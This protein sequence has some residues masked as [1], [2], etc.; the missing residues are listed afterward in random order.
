MGA[1]AAGYTVHAPGTCECTAC[2]GRV[3]HHV[4]WPPAASLGPR[5]Y[6]CAC[7]GSYAPPPTPPLLEGAMAAVRW[8]EPE[9]TEGYTLHAC[10]AG[11]AG[12][13]CVTAGAGGVERRWLAIAGPGGFTVRPAEVMVTH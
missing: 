4:V 8:S 3:W 9:A 10:H 12:G 11:I 1:A 2:G 5:G 7:G 6:A 13:V